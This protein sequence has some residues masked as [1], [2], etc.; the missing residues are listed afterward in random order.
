MQFLLCEDVAIRYLSAIRLFS[1]T[2]L[3]EDIKDSQDFIIIIIIEYF[4]LT[5]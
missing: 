3:L 5:D 4:R 1:S 2:F